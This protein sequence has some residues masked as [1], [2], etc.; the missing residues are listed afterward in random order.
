MARNTGPLPAAIGPYVIVDKIGSGGM[1]TVYRARHPDDGQEVALK[2]LAIHLADRLEGRQRFEREARVLLSLNHPHILPVFDYG[3]DAGTPYLVMRLMSGQSLA[4]VLRG[5]PLPAIRITDYT[6]QISQAL[7]YAHNQGIIHRDVKPTNILIDHQGKLFLADFGVASAAEIGGERL[8]TTGA[9][10][11]TVAY[12]SP[13]QCKGEPLGRPSDIYGLAVMVYEMCTGR[14]PFEAESSL[15]LMKSQIHA[16]IPNPLG[17]N[18]D[19]P[20]DV[21]PVLVRA[22]AK[23]PNARYPSAMKFSEALDEAFGI[24]H[25]DSIDEEDLSWLHGDV[26]P[27]AR[28]AS[29]WVALEPEEAQDDFPFHGIDADV[30]QV[31]DLFDKDNFAADF[32]DE[33]GTES[34][35]AE[36]DPDSADDFDD[37]FDLD[38]FDDDAF[39]GKSARPVIRPIAPQAAAVRPPVPAAYRLPRWVYRPAFLYGVSGVSL[40]IIVAALGLLILHVRESDLALDANVQ[41]PALGIAFDYPGN[42]HT[43]AGEVGMLPG[44][45]APAVFVSDVAVLPGGP[46]TTAG[47]VIA[48]R[49]ASP[50]NV[51]GVPTVC[52][53]RIVDGPAGTFACMAREGYALPVYEVFES[54]GVRLPG[55]LPPT[56]ASPPIILLPGGTDYWLAVI[57]IY[58]DGFDGARDVQARIAR[59]VRRG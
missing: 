50:V 38:G 31:A 37:T 5:R 44:A 9:F 12:A 55:T 28:A 20:A 36:F 2:V 57:V 47:L 54:Q 10:L 17:L 41:V 56:A 18:A 8:T 35:G 33:F 14:R 7:D 32:G 21:Y 53:P 49:H 26:R 13:E 6:R 46:Y 25:L 15:A 52:Q 48:L 45:P 58:W 3:E 23:L 22:L 27:I 24:H 4:G 34:L 11:G 40:L 1:A 59:S 16:P 29:E 39:A 19:L 30:A 42:W 43:S 51:F